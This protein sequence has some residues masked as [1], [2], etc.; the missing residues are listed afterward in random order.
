MDHQQTDIESWLAW[1]KCELSL[2]PPMSATESLIPV[3]RQC[4]DHQQTDIESWLAWLKCELSLLPPM[5]A[6]EFME[7][8]GKLLKQKQQDVNV[9]PSIRHTPQPSIYTDVE[10][11]L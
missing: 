2:L 9:S 1:V 10:R 6:T 8:V 7:S 3:K 11:L 5:S 4:L